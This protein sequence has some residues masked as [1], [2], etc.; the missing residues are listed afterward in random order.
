MRHWRVGRMS[1]RAQGGSP[2]CAGYLSAST[3]LSFGQGTFR[4][5]VSLLDVARPSAIS[6]LS[7]TQCIALNGGCQKSKAY[8]GSS[9]RTGASVVKIGSRGLKVWS[10]MAF[11]PG[12]V[13]GIQQ[14]LIPKGFPQVSKGAPLPCPLLP[15]GVVMGGHENDR[16]LRPA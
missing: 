1:S 6:L 9:P 4:W 5:R 2:I 3:S 15:L 10:F 12:D 13:N 16:E 8:Q 7:E 14:R 11:L